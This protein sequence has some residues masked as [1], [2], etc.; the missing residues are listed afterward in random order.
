[1]IVEFLFGVFVG[2][3]IIIVISHY[4]YKKEHRDFEKRQKNGENYGTRQVSTRS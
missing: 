2:L 1:M 4:S 3:L